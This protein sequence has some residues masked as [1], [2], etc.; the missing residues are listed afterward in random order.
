MASHT[1]VIDQA[2]V[3][4][5]YRDRAARCRQDAARLERTIHGVAAL[6]LGSF[7]G[8]LLLLAEAVASVRARTPCEWGAAIAFVAFLLLI[9]R[10]DQLTAKRRRIADIGVIN[11]QAAYRAERNWA[12]IVP[13]DWSDA[14][15]DRWD[16]DIVGPRSL[17]QLLAPV[18]TLGRRCLWEWFGE[19]ASIADIVQRQ[20]AVQELVGR[21][22]LR[23]P[24]AAYGLRARVSAGGVAT[25]IDWATAAREPASPLMNAASLV[26][27][28]STIALL[29]LRFLE[30]ISGPFWLLPVAIMVGLNVRVS[31]RTRAVLQPVADLSSIA[32]AYVEILALFERQSFQSA[33]LR[34]VQRRLGSST[35]RSAFVGIRKLGRIVVWAQDAAPMLHAA[36]QAALMWDWHLARRLDKWRSTFGGAVSGWLEAL[37]ELESLAALAALAEANPDWAFPAIESRAPAQIEARALGHPLLPA[38]SLVRNDVVIGPPGTVEIISGSNMSG[39]STLLRAVGVNVILARAG[40]PVCAASMRCPQV[41]MLTSIQIHDSLQQGLSYFMAE[42][43]RLKTIIDAAEQS[44]REQGLPVLYLIDEILRGTNSAERA[45]AV[46]IV[47]RRLLQGNSL[48]IITAHD[49]G[50]F[51]HPDIAPHV[52]HFHFGEMVERSG[53]AGGVA[54]DHHLHSG[55]ATSTNALKLLALAGIAPTAMGQIPDTFLAERRAD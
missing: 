54:F 31:R 8:V 32:S 51:D 33:A 42:I 16:L 48:G 35:D 41:R 28:A 34:D 49:L 19:G 5:R 2:S 14:G 22:D 6:R 36:L 37:G 13:N 38:P 20:E 39:K 50:M 40:G 43:T 52:R 55:P 47:V 46:Q 9:R 3:I 15:G 30:V 45:I 18:S 21:T 1:G 10:S 7:V 44:M 53:A 11:E 24:L 25:L 17:V 26:L 4:Q 12:E 27:P 29:V 23:E